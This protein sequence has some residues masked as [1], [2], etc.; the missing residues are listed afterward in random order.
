MTLEIPYSSHTLRVYD[1]VQTTMYFMFTIIHY[2]SLLY[3]MTCLFF[4]EEKLN[5]SIFIL[6]LTSGCYFLFTCFILDKA[7]EIKTTDEQSKK[8][9]EIII[10]FIVFNL[11]FSMFF[12]V[13]FNYL[14]FVYF[15]FEFQI[16]DNN[17]FGI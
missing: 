17:I 16:S 5:A 15:K 13:L 9:R 10:N 4:V 12:T 8:Q 2:L 11:L 7:R 1:S 6:L 14:F 3:F